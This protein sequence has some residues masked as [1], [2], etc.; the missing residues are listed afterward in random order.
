MLSCRHIS[1]Q[2]PQTCKTTGG[3]KKKRAHLSLSSSFFRSFMSRWTTFRTCSASSSVRPDRSSF[4]PMVPCFAVLPVQGGSTRG[5]TG[6]AARGAEAGRTLGGR[7][8]TGRVRMDIMVLICVRSVHSLFIRF[9]WDTCGVAA[10][11]HTESSSG[12]CSAHS[13]THV[14]RLCLNANESLKTGGLA[15]GLAARP[16]SVQNEDQPGPSFRSLAPMR[17]VTLP[18]NKVIISKQQR[19]A[20]KANNATMFCLLW[21]FEKQKTHSGAAQEASSCAGV[22]SAECGFCFWNCELERVRGE[23]AGE[24]E[25]RGAPRAF[26]SLISMNRKKV[27]WCML[28]EWARQV[29]QRAPVRTVVGYLVVHLVMQWW[30]KFK[31]LKKKKKPYKSL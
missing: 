24:R 4:R 26:S 6:V 13:Q 1:Q 18:L 10:A 15:Q 11:P 29:S 8:K 5:G 20:A 14:V 27:P 25:G 2:W 23:T 22:W 21:L 28:R 17:S 16:P 31:W 7:S 19:S 9:S 3:K 30:D 12:V